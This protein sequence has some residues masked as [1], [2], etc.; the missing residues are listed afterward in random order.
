MKF[1][2]Q[3]DLIILKIHNVPTMSPQTS[4]L[5][6]LGM[7][8]HITDHAVHNDNLFI[9]PDNYRFFLSKYEEKLKWV[10]DT[11]AYC[12][13]PNHF[14]LAIQVKSK[15]A[16]LEAPPEVLEKWQLSADSTSLIFQ[17]RVSQQ[18]SNVLNSYAQA[19]NKQRK[20]RGA[21]YDDNFSRS[22]VFTSSYFYNMICYIHHNPV[23]HGFCTDFRDWKHSSYAALLS[24]ETTFL[25]RDVII[26]R[27]GGKEGFIASQENWKQ[28]P[29]K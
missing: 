12:L 2:I 25:K 10:V 4:V 9:D 16:I 20:R 17:E 29:L 14:H 26:N 22:P 7:V 18:F 3:N 21:L 19:V 13:M 8:Y 15:A 5:L 24:D 27:F 28:K 6:D 11:F 1:V 23:K